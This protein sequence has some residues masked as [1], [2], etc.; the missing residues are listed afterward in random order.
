MVPAYEYELKKRRLYHRLLA[1]VNVSYGP[2]LSETLL[3]NSRRLLVYVSVSLREQLKYVPGDK[4][5]RINFALFSDAIL[6]VKSRSSITRN[7]VFFI[8]L[9]AHSTH[10]LGDKISE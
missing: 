7:Y 9:V 4:Y 1:G 10:K 3:T 8:S 6:H 2:H 5:R